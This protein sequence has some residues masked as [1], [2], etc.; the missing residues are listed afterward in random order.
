[1][2]LQV[3]GALWADLRI[4]QRVTAYLLHN[5]PA[6]CRLRRPKSLR[7]GGEAKASPNRAIMSQ[8]ADPKPSDLPMARLNSE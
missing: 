4:G 8:V 6:S 3:V 1:M 7:E 5:G 2:H